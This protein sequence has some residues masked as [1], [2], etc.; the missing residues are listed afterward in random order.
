MN[1]AWQDLREALRRLLRHPRYAL[2]AISL[3]GL[4]I[5]AA[6]GVFSVFDALLL[7]P[8]PVARPE[9]L[10]RAVQ[11]KI[12][13]G[14]RGEFRREAFEALR[15]HSRTLNTVAAAHQVN[16]ALRD[17]GQTT[18]VRVEAASDSYFTLFEPRPQIGRAPD[19]DD[20][21]MLSFAYWR[22]RYAA[23]P[24][25]L[26]RA[27]YL[28]ERPFQVVGVASRKFRGAS[29][30]SCPDA[31]VPLRATELFYPEAKSRDE[32]VGYEIYGR[33]RDGVP[34]EQAREETYGLFVA[35]IRRAMP[36]GERLGKERRES[37]LAGEFSLERVPRGVSRWRTQQSGTMW[38]LMA[39]VGVLCLMTAASVAGILLARFAACRR[40]FSTRLA[41]GASPARLFRLAGFEALVL[42]VGGGA[43]GAT[44]AV[45]LARLIPQMLP[46]VRL[47]D[48]TT[49]PLALHVQVDWRVLGFV[50][51][52]A[53]VTTVLTGVA[54][55]WQAAHTDLAPALRSTRST[56]R[57]R[58]RALFVVLEISLCT[59]LLV[60]AVQLAATLRNLKL[61]P[62]GFST[63]NVVSFT[64]DPYLSGS[65]PR[66][67]GRLLDSLR[68]EVKTLPG[69][70][71]A[72]LSD[73]PLL[74]GSGVKT[75]VAPAGQ[76]ASRRDFLNTSLHVV[77]PDYFDTLGVRILAGRALAAG[78]AEA[79][80]QRMVV[81][82]A[83]A[84]R[85]FPGQDAVGKRFGR[86]IEGEAK[87]EIEIVGVATNAR[88]RSLREP[89]TPTFYQLLTLADGPLVRQS[90][91]VVLYART[92]APPR[93]VIPEIRK[94][95][96]SRAPGMP[97]SE[98]STME[99]DIDTS[100]A[101][102][103]LVAALAGGFGLLAVLIAAA[104][105]FGLLAFTVA[106][107]RREIA[108]RVAVGATQA[109]V[110]GLI[111]RQTARLT[112]G[113]IAIGLVGSWVAGRAIESLLYGMR[114]QDAGARLL[115]AL[116]V[117]G[118]SVAATV[119]P[120]AQALSIAPADALRE[121]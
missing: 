114:A 65:D 86:V 33:L 20:E 93:V 105:L 41:L 15:D 90:G 7:R 91:S 85:F 61:S 104:G 32:I 119:V 5:G 1:T 57:A 103:K 83:F 80:P 102:E 70:E 79:S 82:Q 89:M 81:N 87:P 113:G 109:G 49:V 29:V 26:G 106:Q 94:L 77:T 25:V 18:R 3:L 74:R 108:I 55:A 64:L 16:A 27:V 78:D 13:L 71:S 45:A 31:W 36:D 2:L 92:V 59:T 19:K 34:L 68:E 63:R 62:T 51:L 37:E 120:L 50:A 67:I 22:S 73:R 30:E 38:F 101:A 14:A 10:V 98:V 84:D 97:I 72:A 52:L 47:L 43:V 24:N 76:R 9:T 46:P 40:E 75:T 6:A 35:A 39:A 4:G 53:L 115:A 60:A 121:E 8:L 48:T 21:T 12:G 100:L 42:A 99:A 107:R 95:L 111:G 54:P 116:L 112:A 23:D 58:G 56:G 118:V 117:A 28:N 17:Q 88:Y 110:A 96:E 44:G 11:H 69:V 66:Q